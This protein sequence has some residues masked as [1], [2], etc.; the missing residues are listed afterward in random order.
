MLAGK[1]AVGLAA[2]PRP[3][4]ARTP[5][6]PGR[7]HPLEVVR[8]D[9]GRLRLARR[10]VAATAELDAVDVRGD[11]VHL[12]VRPPGGVEPGCHLLLLDTDDQVLGDAARDR[13]RR[14]ASRR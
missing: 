1:A 7:H 8:L 4:P 5:L 6:A 9:D 10:T 3:P 2:A 14:A 11:R 12:R 13:A